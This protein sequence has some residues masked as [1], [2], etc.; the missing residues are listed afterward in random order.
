[1]ND[2]ALVL[3]YYTHTDLDLAEKMLL[4]CVEMGTQQLEDE[5]LDEDARWELRNAWGDAHQ[6]LGVLY[7]NLRDN[8]KEAERWFQKSVEIGPEPRPLLTN[9]WL[10]LV[11]G[12]LEQVAEFEHDPGAPRN[13]SVAPARK[14]RLRSTAR[15]SRMPAARLG[16]VSSRLNSPV[17]SSCH[18]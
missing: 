9:Y 11:R 1:M 13:G 12:Q 4:A 8:L 10:P 2:T 17:A 5:S 14:R 3:V 6:N 18:P 15:P 16:A 7:A